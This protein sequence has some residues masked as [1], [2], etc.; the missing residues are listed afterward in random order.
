MRQH[1]TDSLEFLAD[2]H[3]LSKIKVRFLQRLE[4][5]FQFQWQSPNPRII[6]NN[7]S[8]ATTKETDA[9]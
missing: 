6:S 2:F 9:A 4:S 1:L 5:F 3:S 7:C 8:R